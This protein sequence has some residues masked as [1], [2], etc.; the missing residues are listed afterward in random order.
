MSELR[1]AQQI[2]QRLKEADRD[3]AKGLTVADVCRNLGLAENTY[4]SRQKVCNMLMPV[5]CLI[6]TTDGCR[7]PSTPPAYCAGGPSI[8]S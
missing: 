1:T 8:L 5:G 6:P 4:G 7:M 3:L 2:Q